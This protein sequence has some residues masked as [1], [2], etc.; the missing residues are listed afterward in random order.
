MPGETPD[1]PGV[2]GAAGQAV[3]PVSDRYPVAAG[4]LTGFD[5]HRGSPGHRADECVDASRTELTDS[6]CVGCRICY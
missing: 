1:E 6:M 5:K 4:D 2:L 3:V